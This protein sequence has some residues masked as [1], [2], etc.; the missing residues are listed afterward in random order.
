MK[1]VGYLWGYKFR[2]LAGG[3]WSLK[4]GWPFRTCLWIKT[5]FFSGQWMLSS[6]IQGEQP[7]DDEVWMLDT[8]AVLHFAL[9]C[10]R[11]L[12]GG[13]REGRRNNSCSLT[14]FNLSFHGSPQKIVSFLKWKRNGKSFLPSSFHAYAQSF[15]FFLLFI[16]FFNDLSS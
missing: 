14:W 6:V 5:H 13:D 9:G 2:C 1:D 7:Q 10:P 11:G 16:Y 15:F 12:A 3:S 8:L 4:P